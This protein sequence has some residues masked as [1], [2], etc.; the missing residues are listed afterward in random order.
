MSLAYIHVDAKRSEKVILWSRIYLLGVLFQFFALAVTDGT[1]GTAIPNAVFG[2]TTVLAIFGLIFL[3]QWTDSLYITAR[4]IQPEGFGYRKGWTFWGW[5]IPI[6]NLWIP[7][8]IID[9]T[10]K[11]M[12]GSIGE[13][14]SLKS[15][16]WW[17][18]WIG[19]SAISIFGFNGQAE[20]TSM[21][22]SAALI[23]A[24]LLTWAYS[25][26]ITIVKTVTKAQLDAVAKV[27]G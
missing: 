26:W 6:A 22:R 5:V 27:N 13:P 12:T 17:A 14:Q 7:K 21:Q 25:H 23:S 18:L 16:T 3:W 2:I 20:I 19:A 4:A 24:L 9:N 10:Y 15:R 11:I 1:D 8:R